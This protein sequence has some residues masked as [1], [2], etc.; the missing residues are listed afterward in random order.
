MKLSPHFAVHRA[1]LSN[2]GRGED[3]TLGAVRYHKSIHLT[4]SHA[5][6]GDDIGESGEGSLS[7][8]LHEWLS[9]PFVL[10]FSEIQCDDESHPPG[11][12]NEGRR[13]ERGER[14]SGPSCSTG[15][16]Y[17]VDMT[18]RLR[19]CRWASG[20]GDTGLSLSSFSKTPPLIPRIP[21]IT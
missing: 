6:D 21:F 17:E 16:R 7:K 2:A 15:P 10:S 4:C 13:G 20:L 5:S 19:A 18:V 11:T 12:G 14:G 3:Y 9:L 8:Q 1:N